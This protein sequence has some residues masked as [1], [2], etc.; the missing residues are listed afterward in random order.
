MCV[1][2]A[3]ADG[4]CFAPHHHHHNEHT[5]VHCEDEH[6]VVGGLSGALMGGTGCAASGAFGAMIGHGLC[7][8]FIHKGV[9]PQEAAKMAKM[10]ST[11]SGIL[12]GHNPAVANHTGVQAIDHNCL[13]HLQ[14]HQRTESAAAEEEDD[15]LM[16]DPVSMAPS[17]H[18]PR[19]V[20]EEEALSHPHQHEG[21]LTD[22]HEAEL[23][24]LFGHSPAAAGSEEDVFIRPPSPTNME[25]C[26]QRIKTAMTEGVYKALPEQVKQLFSIAQE[27]ASLPLPEPEGVLGIIEREANYIHANEALGRGVRNGHCLYEKWYAQKPTYCG[28]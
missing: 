1:L 20:G 17:R 3:L 27:I 8:H 14:D 9:S 23:S 26:V 2:P 16:D 12:I 15:A 5:H 4:V 6:G 22:V 7:E 19:G 28:C 18:A 13:A 24:V 10:I 25:T 11:L 21:L